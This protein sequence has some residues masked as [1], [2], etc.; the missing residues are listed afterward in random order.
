MKLCPECQHINEL[1]AAF[2]VKCGF[3]LSQKQKCHKCSADNPDFANYC[4][5]CGSQM[6]DTNCNIDEIRILKEMSAEKAKKI[7]GYKWGGSYYELLD[8][9]VGF[10]YLSG[11]EN[12]DGTSLEPGA[13]SVIMHACKKG[14]HFS[15]SQGFLTSSYIG[16]SYDEIIDISFAEGDNIQESG[17]VIGG[18]VLGGILLGPLG[19][20]LGGMSQAGSVDIKPSL[21]VIRH[22]SK[23]NKKG[24]L[25]F[26][27]KKGYKD[28]VHKFIVSNDHISQFYKSK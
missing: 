3:N 17:S 7:T 25:I 16:I 22:E 9:N 18:A 13:Y 4:M 1:E 20:I 8:P 6:K 12:N 26:T 2:C 28:K 21:L 14:L 23:D 19:A 11:I 5:K 10:K 15:L 27:I 24:M